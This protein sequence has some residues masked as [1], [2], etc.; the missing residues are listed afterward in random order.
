MSRQRVTANPYL[1]S[2]LGGARLAPVEPDRRLGSFRQEQSEWE[3]PDLEDAYLSR[4]E[5]DDLA[6]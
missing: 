1:E 4:E 5:I 3:T 2:M 6:T